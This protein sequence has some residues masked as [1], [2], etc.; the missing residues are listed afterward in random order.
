METKEPLSYGIGKLD[1]EAR[2]YRR[3]EEDRKY[4]YDGDIRIEE[5]L[6]VLEDKSALFA[7]CRDSKITVKGN[8]KAYY[9][10]LAPEGSSFFYRWKC[11]WN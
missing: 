1:V 2:L 4:I 8:L 11:R 3:N 6:P 5:G 9:T 7:F 10:I